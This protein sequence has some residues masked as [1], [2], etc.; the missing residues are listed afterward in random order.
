MFVSLDHFLTNWLG[1]ATDIGASSWFQAFTWIAALIA[2]LVAA[3]ALRRSTLQ[4]RATLLLAM[5]KTWEDL[6]DER[7]EF[8]DFFQTVR[9]E[10]MEQHD[11]L[12]ESG[13]VE[14]MSGLHPVWLTPG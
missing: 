2:T 4:S 1:N 7:N 11:N 6:D 13:Q 9:L 14:L 12:H 10:V 5:Y 8:Y 3:V